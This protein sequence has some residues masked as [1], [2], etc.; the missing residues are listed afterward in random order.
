MQVLL[1][2]LVKLHEMTGGQRNILIDSN[3]RPVLADFGLVRLAEAG[4]FGKFTGTSDANTPCWTSPQR[5]Q[6][7]TRDPT[8]DVY[9]YG[10][11]CYYVGTFIFRY[12]SFSTTLTSTIAIL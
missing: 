5:I 7:S 1:V 6:G 8:D 11:V 9:S 2:L 3:Y 4:V 12:C 10:C